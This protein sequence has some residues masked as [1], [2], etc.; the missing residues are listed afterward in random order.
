MK[1]E[2][3]ILQFGKILGKNGSSRVLNPP[4]HSAMGDRGAF[5]LFSHIWIRHQFVSVVPSCPPHCT[6]HSACLPPG[7]PES[8]HWGRGCHL[9]EEESKGGQSPKPCCC[10]QPSAQP[11]CQADS[12]QQE[13]ADISSS[14][15]WHGWA[16]APWWRAQGVSL[17][18][19]VHPELRAGLSHLPW[20]RGTCLMAACWARAQPARAVLSSATRQHGATALPAGIPPG[21][22]PETTLPFLLLLS[23]ASLA[24][25]SSS[26]CLLHLNPGEGKDSRGCC[27]FATQLASPFCGWLLSRG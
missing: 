9:R 16:A 12:A 14:C 22:H 20:G 19:E 27:W 17:L 11:R 2:H 24:E 18:P 5:N 3:V 26:A 1:H 4:L 25:S 13:Q 7:E 23:P 15:G 8:H 6:S 21:A 10:S